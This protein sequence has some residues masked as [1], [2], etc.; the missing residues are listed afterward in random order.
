MIKP[1]FVFSMPRSGSTLLQ[2][3]LMSHDKISSHS[4]P[5]F[6]LNLASLY[7][8]EGTKSKFCYSALR[9]AVKDVINSLENKEKDMLKYIREFSL[10]IYQNLSDENSVYF[11]D[12][13]P[14]YFFII[15]FIEKVFPE[16]KFIF[17]TRNPLETIAS[18]ITQFNYNTI[19]SFDSYD[20]DFNEGFKAI[21]NGYYKYKNKS[22]LVR[23]EEIVGEDKEQI[24]KNI[25]EYLELK[26]DYKVFDKYQTQDLKG[27]M[28]DKNI[29]KTSSVKKEK[30]KWKK[31]I[32]SNH[33][34]KLLLNILDKIIDDYYKLSDFNKDD[35]LNIL[36]SHNTVFNF[37]DFQDYYLTIVRRDIKNQ[38]GWYKY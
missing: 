25:F 18:Y 23:Y 21:V 34:K 11:I 20:F 33:R 14:R 37:Q 7:E 2:K 8:F 36:K 29:K 1:I 6:L 32:F 31:V 28:G 19:K 16:A 3:L 30:D 4:E 26:P 35:V 38:L 22:I 13:T 27:S 9:V 15:D 10:N 17:L 5:W 24:I 12:K